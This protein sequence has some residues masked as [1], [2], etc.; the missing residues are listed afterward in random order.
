MM[1][2][3]QKAIMRP[4][5]CYFKLS[6]LSDLMAHRCE[7][8]VSLSLRKYQLCTSVLALPSWQQ[9]CQNIG[10]GIAIV[11]IPIISYHCP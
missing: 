7:V 11:T 10:A 3:A 2:S 1:F 4:F 8:L 9:V 5:C 6:L